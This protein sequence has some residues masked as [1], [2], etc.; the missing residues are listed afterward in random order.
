[1][2]LSS[3]AF[4]CL[5]SDMASPSPT[6]CLHLF[7]SMA[8]SSHLSTSH[9]TDFRSPLKTPLMRICGRPRALLLLASSIAQC[10]LGHSSI[11]QRNGMWGV[12]L[13]FRLGFETCHVSGKN[14]IL[15]WLHVSLYLEHF[16]Y[17]VHHYRPSLFL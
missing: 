14:V 6:S 1:M 15:E 8:R 16:I 12:G 11:A 9:S 7:R 2:C 5:A 17:C 3:A 10:I 13:R 4:L